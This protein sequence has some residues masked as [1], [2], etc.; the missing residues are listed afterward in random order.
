MTSKSYKGQAVPAVRMSATSDDYA[1]SL[2]LLERNAQFETGLLRT[3][4]PNAQRHEILNPFP[5]YG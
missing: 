3:F 1:R 4:G 5:N 2:Q